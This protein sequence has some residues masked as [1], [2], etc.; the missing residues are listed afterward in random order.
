M[1]SCM[2]NECH[3]C[4]KNTKYLFHIYIK[5]NTFLPLV[6]AKWWTLV[7]CQND[8]SVGMETPARWFL[9]ILSNNIV[10]KKNA[11]CLTR[12]LNISTKPRPFCLT[13]PPPS[14]KLTSTSL[15]FSTIKYFGYVIIFPLRNSWRINNMHKLANYPNN[16]DREIKFGFLNSGVMV[17]STALILWRYLFK[18]LWNSVIFCL[19][20]CHLIE[21][22]HFLKVFHHF[23]YW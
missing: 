13:S 14:S 22:T 10:L 9:A 5:L 12:I 20:W 23:I 18:Y 16:G 3:S 7:W 11:S 19:G 2:A 17:N 21:Y 1:V 4:L 6:D 8:G 15:S